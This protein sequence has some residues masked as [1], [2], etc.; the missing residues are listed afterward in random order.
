ML[1]TLHILIE[2]EDKHHYVS[3]LQIQKLRP[4]EVDKLVQS[5]TTTEWWDLNSNWPTLESA[6]LT[7]V[8]KMKVKVTQLCPTL[9][10]P[11]DCSLSGSCLWD[12]PCKNTGVDRHSLFQ[13]IFPI[14][15]LN[16]GFL[17]LQTDSLPSEPS[18][19]PL[20]TIDILNTILTSE[21]AICVLPGNLQNTLA[22]WI[23]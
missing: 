8:K 10:N 17:P 6:Q 19:S 21:T 22:Y 16:L 4:N 18:G 13:V 14:Q 3:I 5:H 1:N 2:R 15:G 20:T 11:V 23:D 12:F 7:T 9:C